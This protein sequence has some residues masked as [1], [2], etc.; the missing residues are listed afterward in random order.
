MAQHNNIGKLGESLAVRF[1]EQKGYIVVDKNFRFKNLGEID[2]IA[3]KGQFTHFVEVKA[4]SHEN[5]HGLAINPEENVTPGKLRKLRN[6]ISFYIEKKNIKDWKFS[7]IAVFIDQKTKKAQI[8]FL[9]E[10]ILPE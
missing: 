8:R 4:V 3:Q 2:I 1:L 5:S 7:I 6:I 10:E 9:E